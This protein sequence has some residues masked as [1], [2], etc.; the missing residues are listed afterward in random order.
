M[1]PWIDAGS[2]ATWVVFVMARYSRG[3]PYIVAFP[4]REERSF[5]PDGS[6][7]DENWVHVGRER[8]A[9]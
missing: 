3:C 8:V 1:P 5:V 4:V 6:I 2:P 9:G 7:K